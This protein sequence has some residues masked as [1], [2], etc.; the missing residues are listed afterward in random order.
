[1]LRIVRFIEISCVSDGSLS[2]FGSIVYRRSLIIKTHFPGN[3]ARRADGRCWLPAGMDGRCSAG[4]GGLNVEDEDNGPECW[5]ERY[6]RV[7]VNAF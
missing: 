7:P 1:V 6:F 4:Q 5:P 3:V 2:A